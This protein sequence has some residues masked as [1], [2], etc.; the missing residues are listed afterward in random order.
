[1]FFDDSIYVFKTAVTYFNFV[2][3][4]YFA[5]FISFGEVFSNEVKEFSTNICYYL[6]VKWR[7]KPNH[8]PVSFAFVLIVVRFSGIFIKVYLGVYK[9]AFN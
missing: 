5:E 9:S 1:M 3:V 2:F 8:V 7:G 6:Y 4:E